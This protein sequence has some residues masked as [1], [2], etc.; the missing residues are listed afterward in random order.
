M[1]ARITKSVEAMSKIPSVGIIDL[2]RDER[3]YRFCVGY[4]HFIPAEAHEQAGQRNLLID[5]SKEEDKSLLL[6]I[7]QEMIANGYGEPETLWTR[8]RVA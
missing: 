2:C 5:L 1:S 7:F 4:G 8:P 3:G 6:V